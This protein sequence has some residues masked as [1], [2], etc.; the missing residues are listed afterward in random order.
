MADI[1]FNP[2]A[3]VPFSG[4]ILMKDQTGAGG[5]YVPISM[6]LS[7]PL[8]VQ[9]IVPGTSA[10]GRGSV[11]DNQGVRN[12]HNLV[13]TSSAGVSGGIVALQGSQDNVNWVTLVSTSALGASATV[14][15]V[16]SLTPF[17]Y[18]CANITTII[19]G[20]TVT[21]YIASAG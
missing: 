20:G 2:V 19:S 21:A 6:T 4:P 15:V 17:R 16:T 10:T 3:G 1:T 12:N 18:I 11:L 13:V 7:G 8:P 9:S 14:T 5:P